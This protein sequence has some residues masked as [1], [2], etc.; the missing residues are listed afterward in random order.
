MNDS[1]IGKVFGDIEVIKFLDNKGNSKNYLCKCL[2]CGREK[3]TQI[4]HL[5]NGLGISHKT[6]GLGLKQKDRRFYQIW[7]DM[8]KR[9]TNPNSNEWHNYGGRGITSDD[10]KYFIDF[11]DD[12]YSSYLEH[13]NQYGEKNT[14]IDRINVNESYIKENIRWSTQAEQQNNTRK[15]LRM[16]M[17]ISPNGEKHIFNNIK[18]FSLKFGLPKENVSATIRGVNK[19]CKG[20]KFYRIKEESYGKL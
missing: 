8:R 7:S 10:Y 4:K 18:D 6:C 14:T 13:K 15:Q 1:N 20:W 16:F 9:T 11:Y 17:G 12:F 19:T 2:V 3:R 5:K